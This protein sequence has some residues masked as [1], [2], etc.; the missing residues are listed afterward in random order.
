[1]LE[2]WGIC[3]CNIPKSLDTGVFRCPHFSETYSSLIPEIE[4][5]KQTIIALPYWIQ[6]D[7]AK[8]I[9]FI[10][11][12]LKE[13]FPNFTYINNITVKNKY[14]LGYDNLAILVEDIEVEKT[15]D[16]LQFVKSIYLSLAE[17]TLLPL[18]IPIQK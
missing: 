9:D 7:K 4:K 8:F 13:K 1:M 15:K 10:I 17:N 5:T 2:K 6:E 14:H 12:K 18:I 3:P 16:F 11:E